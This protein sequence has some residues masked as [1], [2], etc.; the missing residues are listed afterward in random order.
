MLA[1]VIALVW[2]GMQIFGG[3]GN[4]PKAAPT[5]PT[6][7]VTT[8]AAPVVKVNGL[9]DV[10]LVGATKP[11][12][13]QLIRIVP[14]VKSGQLT[15]GP[16]QIG[17]VVSSTSPDPCTLTAAEADAIAVISANGTA[18][19]DSTVCKDGLISAPIAVSADWAT[20]ATVEWSG[21]GSGSKCHPNEGYATPGKYTLQ[22]GTL[23]GEPGKVS[24]TLDA[25]PEP[26]PTKT[27]P[28]A[29]TPK[30]GETPKPDKTPKTPKPT[31][32]PADG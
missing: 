13:P 1:G 19:W 14:T 5:T 3:S 29:K 15:K 25:K 2:I 24:F 18:V 22:I 27:T 4:E 20:L 17:L 7:T 11:C 21:R 12:D 32:K 16:V 8:T 9:V 30:A 10:K 28:T 26:K 23:G 6:P 31:S